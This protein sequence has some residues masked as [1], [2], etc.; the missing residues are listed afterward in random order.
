MGTGRW[1]ERVASTPIRSPL[2]LGTATLA[3]SPLRSPCH[4]LTKSVFS[5]KMYRTQTWL[6]SARPASVAAGTSETK[7][8]RQRARGTS[9]GWRGVPFLRPPNQAQV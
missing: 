7:R 1:G 4:T 3:L 8:S 6:Y 5:W 2:S 9:S